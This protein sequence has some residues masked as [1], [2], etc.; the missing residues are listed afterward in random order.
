MQGRTLTFNLKKYQTEFVLSSAKYPALVAGWGTGK[1]LCA[2]LRALDFA[3]EDEDNLGLILRNE[4]KD[5][6]DSTIRDFTTY[7][8]IKVNSDG[9]AIVPVGRGRRPSTIMFRHAEQLN[10]LLNLNLGFAAFIQADEL[11]NEDAFFL[12]TGRLRRH[13][14]RRS[15]WV[16]A[17]AAGHNWV[18]NLWVD[19]GGRD[20]SDY[21][22]WQATSF[23]NQDVHPE[24]YVKSWAGLPERMYKRFILN[25]HSVMEG[26]VW[27][28]FDEG[29]HT[30]DSHEIPPD[31][32]S[33]IG[34]DHGRDHPTA[35]EFGAIGHD[36]KLIIYAEHYEAGQLIVHH[37]RRIKEIEPDWAKMRRYI[38]P[39]CRYKTLQ[40]TGR[41][42]SVRDA[43]IDEGISFQLAP[44][45]A[46]AGINRVGQLFK[47][48]KIVI[49]KDKCP[50]LIRE[51]K[52]W[53]YKQSRV[54]GDVRIKEEP[55]NVGE[56]ACKA[57]IYLTGGHLDATPVAVEKLSNDP[58]LPMACQLV[59]SLQAKT[60]WEAWRGGS[61]N[62]SDWH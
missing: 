20:P 24:D 59:G 58:A 25:D 15:C 56:D 57:L 12:I 40:D 21:P 10:N 9:N 16:T 8:G 46:D 17:N 47:D 1:D 14:K 27:P 7:T 53:K 45:D 18:W 38:D 23:E 44:I 11:P 54:G 19:R 30:C 36:G 41:A 3:R 2:I 48:N 5:L 61:W 39:T 34:L 31:W 32:K 43:Y 22:C 49:F 26:L 55:S 51:I 28:E 37:A 4:Y 60:P 42:Y 35:V 13:T 33:H 50:N 6:A 62:R 29:K 52:T